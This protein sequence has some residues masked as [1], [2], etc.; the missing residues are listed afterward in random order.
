MNSPGKYDFF[1]SFVQ[2]Q[3]Q[4]E[5]VIV[6]VING[7]AGDGM[8]V[9]ATPEITERL[10]EILQRISEL[11]DAAQKAGLSGLDLATPENV[12]RIEAAQTKGAAPVKERPLN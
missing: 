4:A 11:L 1:S 6:C 9:T 5:G 3:T 8:S 12:A 2:R 10:P 7:S